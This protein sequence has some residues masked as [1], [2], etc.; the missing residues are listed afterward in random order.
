MGE[1]AEPQ[2]QPSSAERAR[3][4]LLDHQDVSVTVGRCFARSERP[5]RLFDR[6]DGVPRLVVAHEGAPHLVGKTTSPV[7]SVRVRGH[8]P[9]DL[10]GI[11]A[12]AR[13]EEECQCHGVSLRLEPLSMRWLNADGSRRGEPV[14][15]QSFADAAPDP[16][17]CA[18]RNTLAH[19]SGDHQDDLLAFARDLVDADTIAVEATAIDSYGLELSVIT[20]EGVVRAR[21]PFPRR[22]GDV[23]SASVALRN[24]L[25]SPRPTR[26]ER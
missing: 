9:T 8:R 22:V 25:M 6:G 19:L 10:L 3:T 12:T 26:R 23:E 15:L 2:I 7:L 14:S 21:C 18:A 24:L 5:A 17:V 4:L 11:T 16:L 20:A 1:R 13:R